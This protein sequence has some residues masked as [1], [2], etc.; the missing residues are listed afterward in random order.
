VPLPI[1]GRVA[2]GQMRGVPLLIERERPD[3]TSLPALQFWY[4][5]AGQSKVHEKQ[6]L[7]AIDQFGASC[8]TRGVTLDSFVFDDAGTTTHLWAFT[9]LSQWFHAAD[10]GRRPL[11]LRVGTWLS[12]GRLPRI[13]RSTARVRPRQGSR[14]T[15]RILAADQVLRTVRAVCIEMLK[16]YGVNTSSST[17]SARQCRTGQ[18][19]GASA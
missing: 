1:R 14:P 18:P 19:Y 8:R 5:I 11:S 4:D 6:S 12:P 16:K 2:P 15:Q 3:L 17:A 13:E 10:G 9:R 7:D